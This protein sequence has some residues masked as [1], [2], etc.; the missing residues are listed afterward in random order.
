LKEVFLTLTLGQPPLKIWVFIASMTNEF[1]LGLG[2]RRAYDGSLDLG[3]QTLHLAEEEVSVWSP[4]LGPWPSSL[5]VVN[6][7]MIPAQC[8]G[9]VM[10][11]LESLLEVENSLE[12]CLVEPSS[13]A[14]PPEGLYIA[15]TLVQNCREV[16]MRVLNATS[17]DQMLTK[18]SP[19]AH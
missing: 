5:V 9:V 12:N 13:K 1:I 3:R 7:Q 10:D 6:D 16:T 17:H 15:R 2:V 8:K 19:L 14:H 18:G 11:R 4:G